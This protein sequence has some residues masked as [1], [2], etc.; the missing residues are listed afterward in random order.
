MARRGN[1]RMPKNP[2]VEEE[3]DEYGYAPAVSFPPLAFLYL[4]P[5]QSSVPSQWRSQFIVHRS[6]RLF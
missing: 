2:A 6:S 1:V 3:K 5:T 4:A